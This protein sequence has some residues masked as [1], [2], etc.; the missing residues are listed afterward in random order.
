M[1]LAYVVTPGDTT[2]SITQHYTG[3]ARRS[4]ELVAAN[5]TKPS[6]QVGGYWTFD[7]LV[8]GETIWL[9]DN[10]FVAAYR[11]PYYAPP[12]RTP[13]YFDYLRYAY[14]LRSP[15]MIRFP[16]HFVPRPP[17]P[18]PRIAM[19]MGRGLGAASIPET[20]IPD[21]TVVGGLTPVEP[22][23]A[24]K[25]CRS[26]FRTATNGDI[27]AGL[28][29]QDM[30][31]QTVDVANKFSGTP[32]TARYGIYDPPGNNR[33]TMY[34]FVADGG[35]RGHLEICET[36]DESLLQPPGTPPPFPIPPVCQPGNPNYNPNDPNCPKPVVLPPGGGGGGAA[37]GGLGT[38][39]LLLIG[40]AAV[41]AGA[42]LAYAVSQSGKKKPPMRTPAHSPLAFV[43]HP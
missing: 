19:G 5:P 31:D 28:W 29:T 38:G 39:T 32:G 14:L 17:S 11:Q 15:W 22:S 34:K 37:G 6:H 42:G 35:G 16:D 33:P 41:A 43:A 21:F 30:T 26:G 23:L 7:S 18:R 9:P 3:D 25:A 36:F 2:Y 1:P 40:A 12:Y 20:Y 24:V 10:W 4:A 13:S 27:Q 8:A